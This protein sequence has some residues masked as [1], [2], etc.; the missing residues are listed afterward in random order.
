MAF[1]EDFRVVTAEE[2]YQALDFLKEHEC[3]LVVSDL[4]MPGLRGDELCRR[5]KQNL[6]T[7]WM[8]VVLLTAVNEK[9]LVLEG[10]Q[11]GAW[12][13]APMTI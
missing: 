12:T 7:S 6:D 10:L 9:E 8:P 5:I 13:S 11:T 4:V 1:G 2:A 3:D